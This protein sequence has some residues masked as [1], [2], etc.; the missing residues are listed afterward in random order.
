[1]NFEKEMEELQAFHKKNTWDNAC[2]FILAIVAITLITLL[3]LKGYLTAEEHI[4]L[5]IIALLLQVLYG[6]SILQRWDKRRS[7]SLMK[8]KNDVFI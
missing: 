3:R 8:G 1:M 5:G 2:S 4:K 6:R 7:N